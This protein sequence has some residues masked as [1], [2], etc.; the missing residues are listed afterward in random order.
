MQ[1]THQNKKKPMVT[2]EEVMTKF[3]AMDVND[4]GRISKTEYV[5]FHDKIDR[6]KNEL[7]A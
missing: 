5:Q 2:D 1:R 3:A 7:I 6:T 4:D